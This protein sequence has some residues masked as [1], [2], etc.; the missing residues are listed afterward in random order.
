MTMPNDPTTTPSGEA[1]MPQIGKTG[2]GRSAQNLDPAG[3]VDKAVGAVASAAS[4]SLKEARTFLDKDQAK[5][6]ANKAKDT[7]AETLST[8]TDRVNAVRDQVQHQAEVA[9]DWAKKQA[10]QAAD[11]A[12][13]LHAERPVLVISV[14]AATAL[15]VGLAAGFVIG[16]ATADE[17]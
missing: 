5:Q 16:R 6:M 17:Y 1:D 9:R 4:S 7:A 14:S 3:E 13:Q 10:E 2:R 15:L 8:L 12:K 11:A